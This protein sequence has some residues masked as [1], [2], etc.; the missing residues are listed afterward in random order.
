MEVVPC[1]NQVAGNRKQKEEPQVEN[2]CNTKAWSL[3]QK[4][5]TVVA[6]NLSDEESEFYDYEGRRCKM[7]PAG[8]YVFQHCETTDT[9]SS[10]KP[11]SSDSFTMHLNRF[12][13][14]VPCKICRPLDQ[15]TLKSCSTTSNAECACNKGTFCLPDQPCET[16]HKCKPRC[17]DGEQMVQPCTSQSDIQCMPVP[18]SS[19]TPSSEQNNHTRTKANS[20]HSKLSPSHLYVGN[21]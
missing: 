12:H 18:T 19:P 7:C 5:F 3:S 21:Y 1:I 20:I 4:N 11:C 6:S 2:G 8:S 9:E 10:C 14:C 13:A 16:C 15:V 17:P